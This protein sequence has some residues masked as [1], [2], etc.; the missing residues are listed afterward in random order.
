[1]CS[2]FFYEYNAVFSV[3]EYD[4]TLKSN[5]MLVK[6]P[7]AILWETEQNTR[8]TGLTTIILSLY[9]YEIYYCFFKFW[10]SCLVIS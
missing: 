4:L 5:A 6:K 8:Y 3:I 1:M 10:Q 2:L 7:F 9:I